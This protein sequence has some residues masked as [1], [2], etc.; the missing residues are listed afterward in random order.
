M[1]IVMRGIWQSAF[2]VFAAT[3]GFVGEATAG[4]PKPA[5]TALKS[6]RLF[7]GKAD[8]LVHDG[9][10]LVEGPKIVAV[11]SGLSIPDGATVIDL[12]DATLSPGFID[13][14]THLTSEY[15]DDWN[16]AF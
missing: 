6:A 12:G 5:V 10:V 16:R 9:V 4:G 7:D 1:R 3:A 2:A 8:E 14:H 15:D 13:A 11:G